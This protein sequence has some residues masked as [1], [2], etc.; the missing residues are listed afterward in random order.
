MI[1]INL[2]N[3]SESQY[4]LP[5][6]RASL[7]QLGLIKPENKNKIRLVVYFHESNEDV[8]TPILH[9]AVENGIDVSAALMKSDAYMDKV[10]IVNQ[11]E[12]PYMCK[13]DDDVFINRHVWDFMIDNID[14]L[15]DPKVGIVCPTLS[16]GIPSAGIF[17]DDFLT[18]QERDTVHKIFLKDNV[19]AD[20][21][22]SNHQ[23]VYD[24]VSKMESWN[25]LD[26]WK[27]VDRNN[28]IKNRNL[29]W[30]M[31]I[32]KGV[33]P[34]RFSYD[35][36]MFLAKHAESNIDL[37]AQKRDM[38]FVKYKAPYVCNN[39][40]LCKTELYKE[41]QKMFFDHWDEGQLTAYMNFHDKVPMFVKN[42][43]GIHMAYGCTKGQKD[44]E[45]YYIKNVFDKL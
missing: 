4:R 27:I 13:W 7:K 10:S 30:Y 35:Y 41:S 20:I 9:Q 19:I 5:V 44:I 24:A 11:S 21:W 6:V 43:Y 36:N 1:Q 45:N 32:A 28:P 26:Y 31:I 2:F 18:Q 42:C 15:E 38:S 33:H 34:S 14:I 22:G 39:L 25:D 37:I 16:N 8:W 17:I 3:S 23:D 29:A 40:F 12:D